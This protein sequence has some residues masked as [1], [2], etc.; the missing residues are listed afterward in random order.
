MINHSQGLELISLKHHD[1]WFSRRSFSVTK[2]VFHHTLDT[3]SNLLARVMR[4]I[5]SSSW[6]RDQQLGLDPISMEASDLFQE[7]HLVARH[8][9]L[10]ISIPPK[11]IVAI[12]SASSSNHVFLSSRTSECRPVFG[13]VEDS[14][15]LAMGEPSWANGRK[16]RV[17]EVW[18]ERKDRERPRL[19]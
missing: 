7:H 17:E 6:T 9:L 1:V 11:P 18:R 5:S 12:P 13:V 4:D 2:T 14:R 10:A 16:D 15:H 19:S 3:I 8:Q